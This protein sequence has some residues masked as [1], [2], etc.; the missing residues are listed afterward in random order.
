MIAE[1]RGRGRIHDAHAVI[2]AEQWT[3]H[4]TAAAPARPAPGLTGLILA[5]VMP[6]DPALLAEW[7]QWYDATHLPDMMASGAFAAGSR[8]RRASPVEVGPNH[9]TLYDIDVS[10]VEA[11]V[12][13][14]AAAM[15]ALIA[16]GRKHRA[17]LGALTVVLQATAVRT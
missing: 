4:G 14:S 8:W 17:H 12:Q 11:A 7:D 9:L 15:P 6:N 5:Q 13:R 16:G 1:L 3:A 10:P 2:A